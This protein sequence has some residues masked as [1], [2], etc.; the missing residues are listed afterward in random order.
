MK[1]WILVFILIQTSAIAQTTKDHCTSVNHLGELGPARNQGQ[2][3]W[4]YGYAAADLLSY[5]LKVKISA[6]AV[7]FS[8]AK[9]Q[10]KARDA[11]NTDGGDTTVALRRALRVGLCREES[12]PSDGDALAPNLGADARL[13]RSELKDQCLDRLFPTSIAIYKKR[14]RGDITLINQILDDNNIVSTGLDGDIFQTENKEKYKTD[15]A[16]V[17]VGRRWND[18][19]NRCE[20]LFRNAWESNCDGYRMDRDCV[21]GHIWLS[22]SDV[23]KSVTD[24]TYLTDSSFKD[25]E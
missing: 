13:F 25:R 24:I 11:K 9:I 4:C 5:L 1:S 8:P 6:A 18:F 16:S 7:V 10:L 19:E 12:F 20:Y 22:E 14:V 17:I 15:H 3:G 21:Q 2:T 23:V